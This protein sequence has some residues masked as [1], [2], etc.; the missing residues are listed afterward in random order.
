MRH[1]LDYLFHVAQHLLAAQPLPLMDLCRDSIRKFIVSAGG[2]KALLRLKEFHYPTG[3]VNY[4][5]H[6]CCVVQT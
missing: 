5:I 4:I 1:I 6:R 2:S 3:L